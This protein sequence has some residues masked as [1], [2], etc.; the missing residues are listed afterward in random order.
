MSLKSFYNS[1]LRSATIWCGNKWRDRANIIKWSCCV[2]NERVG[3][4]HQLVAN[5]WTL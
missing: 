3:T 1:E 5:T 2:E 4:D